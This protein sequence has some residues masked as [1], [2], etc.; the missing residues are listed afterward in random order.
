MSWNMCRRGEFDEYSNSCRASRH[1][2]TQKNFRYLETPN[3]YPAERNCEFHIVCNKHQ[4]IEYR[5]IQSSFLP[6][7]AVEID[8]ETVEISPR[9]KFQ[10]FKTIRTDSN[11][12][13]IRYV[14]RIRNDWEKKPGLKMIWKCILPENYTSK[15][16]P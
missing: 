6:R 8:G 15:M 4:V 13:S 7:D 12:M 2:S 10:K 9:T 16:S 1:I 11:T 3:P 5:V 14:T